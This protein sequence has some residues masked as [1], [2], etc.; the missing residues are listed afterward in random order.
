M[1]A[2]FLYVL[3]NPSMPGLAKV[4]K[5]TRNPSDRVSELSSATGVAT[6]FLLAYQQP[7][8]DCDAA[9]SWVHSELERGGHR[10]SSNREFFS[11]LL[12]EIVAVIAKSAEIAPDVTETQASETAA[13]STAALIGELMALAHAYKEGTTDVIRNE[14]KAYNCYAQAGKLGSADGC[15]LAGASLLS[16]ERGRRDP[17]GALDWFKRAVSLGAWSTLGDIANLF[18]NVGQRE[19]AEASWSKFWA[20][21]QYEPDAVRHVGIGGASYFLSLV[22]KRVGH[23][24]TEKQVLPHAKLILNSLLAYHSAA[25]EELDKEW[26]QESDIRCRDLFIASQMVEEIIARG[27]EAN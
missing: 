20:A 9:E 19:S 24:A 22:R 14:Q 18:S 13:G 3:I 7:V 17:D 16:P 4:G 27:S 21:A 15:F 11:A 2:G 25:Q 5:T 1:T 8:R 23:I 26:D 6:P 10:V 12:H